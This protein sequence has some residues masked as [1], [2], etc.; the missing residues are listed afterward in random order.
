MQPT[1][2]RQG[3]VRLACC[4][5]QPACE[6][7]TVALYRGEGC[8]RLSGGVVLTALEQSAVAVG[9]RQLF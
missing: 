5:A 4:R 9:V 2:S 6:S 3:G 8:T 7:L 1:P